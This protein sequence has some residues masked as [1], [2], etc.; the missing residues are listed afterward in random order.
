MKLEAIAQDMVKASRFGIKIERLARKRKDE[1]IPYGP[2][3]VR[4]CDGASVTFDDQSVFDP[5]RRSRERLDSLIKNRRSYILNDIK[6]ILSTP[7]QHIT[8][9]DIEQVQN[10]AKWYDALDNP[11]I[12]N[13]ADGPRIKQRITVGLNPAWCYYLVADSPDQ[14]LSVENK[15]RECISPLRDYV[16]GRQCSS[17]LEQ[18]N[19]I[20]EDS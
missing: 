19:A 15:I 11:I 9:E 5:V 6:E 13:E 4:F 14:S 12:V 20:D 1:E 3:Q 18:L 10:L 7:C 17:L 8:K 16:M 2:Y